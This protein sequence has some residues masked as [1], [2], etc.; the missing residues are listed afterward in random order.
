MTIPVVV[1]AAIAVTAAAPVLLFVSWLLSFHR[2]LRGLPRTLAFVVCYLWCET[3][4]ILVAG[5]LWVRFRA[6]TEAD[7]T[8]RAYLLAN[9]RLQCAWAGALKH[10]TQAVFSLEFRVTGDTV[11]EGDGAILMARHVSMADTVIPM[12]FYAIPHRIRLRYVLKQELLIDPC[13]DIVG[14][15]LPNCFVDRHAED[16]APEVAR[17]GALATHLDRD[18]GVLIYPEGTRFSAE[19]RERVLARLASQVGAGEFARMQRWTNLLPPRLGGPAALLRNNPGRDLAFCAHVGFEMASHLKDLVSGEW[20]GRC[21]RI[22]FW[23]VP[24]AEIPVDESARRE[25]LFAQWDRMQETVLALQSG[26][27]GDGQGAV[28][29][30][31]A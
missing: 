4:G 7:A 24:F 6:P 21:I 23:R 1:F 3:A 27:D 8:W 25:F 2:A 19:R 13:L 16:S 15:R 17:V 18:E 26:E 10:A 31:G 11:L 5:W 30:R 22:H 20:T 29:S 12:V 9:Y 28:L 14:H